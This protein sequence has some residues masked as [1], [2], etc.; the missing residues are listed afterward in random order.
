MQRIF[1][2]VCRFLLKNLSLSSKLLGKLLFT[3]SY[4]ENNMFQL[5][6]IVGCVTVGEGASIRARVAIRA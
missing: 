6:T 5:C 3:N 1:D 2:S 4:D